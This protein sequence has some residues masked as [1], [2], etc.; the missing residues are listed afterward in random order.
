MSRALL[1]E[2]EAREYVGGGYRSVRSK[3][4]AVTM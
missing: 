3:R 2:E 4:S 1:C